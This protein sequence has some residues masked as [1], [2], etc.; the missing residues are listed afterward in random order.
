MVAAW[1]VAAVLGRAAARCCGAVMVVV[2]VVLRM[3]SFVL[4][5]CTSTTVGTAPP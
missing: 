1:S 5:A 2:L 4:H 3:F